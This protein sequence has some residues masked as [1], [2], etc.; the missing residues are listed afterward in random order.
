M[1]LN[2]W[3][4]FEFLKDRTLA[5]GHIP[6]RQELEDEFSSIDPEEIEGGIQELRV[7]LGRWGE[8]I[9]LNNC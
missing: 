2:K 9:S 1:E 3:S 6:T 4:V 5:T 8:V 7:R